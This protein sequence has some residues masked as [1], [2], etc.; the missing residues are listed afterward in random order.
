MGPALPPAAH[1]HREG[2]ERRGSTVAPGLAGWAVR[3]SSLADLVEAFSGCCLCV[4]SLC[5]QA[6]ERLAV[7]RLWPVSGVCCAVP[8]AV[9]A[10]LASGRL[11]VCAYGGAWGLSVLG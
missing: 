10:C 1:R 7:L 11:Y 5:S 3:M 9:S 6:T 8:Q 2:I 4:S